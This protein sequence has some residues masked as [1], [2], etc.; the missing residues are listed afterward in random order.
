M[1][2]EK[3]HRHR[4]SESPLAL[5]SRAGANVDFAAQ[6]REDRNKEVEEFAQSSLPYLSGE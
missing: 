5:M 1:S 2:P 4:S 3:R 6:L